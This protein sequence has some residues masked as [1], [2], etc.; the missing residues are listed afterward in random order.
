MN[1]YR[2]TIAIC[3]LWAL[4]FGVLAGCQS[5][6]QQ[7]WGVDSLADERALYVAES[8]YS[9]AAAAYLE[10]DSLGIMNE[11]EKQAAKQGLMK[12]YEAIKSARGAF[13]L[14]DV[15]KFNAS[16]D[17]ANMTIRNTRQVIPN[18]VRLSYGD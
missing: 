3:L 8:G 1:L 16:I 7:P 13:V 17:T 6:P 5:A 14:N 11:H 2:A 4:I 15:S 12:A 18:T 10:A 9:V